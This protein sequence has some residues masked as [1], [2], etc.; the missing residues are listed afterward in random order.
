M[1]PLD[2]HLHDTLTQHAADVGAPV[3]LFGAV[4]RRARTLRRRRVAVATAGTAAVAAVAVVG[5]LTLTGG[6][7][8]DTLRAPI[9]HAGSGTPSATS[10]SPAASA[11]A[12]PSPV[13]T[14]T[15]Q[16]AASTNYPMS[17]PRVPD[18]AVAWVDWPAVQ[19]SMAGQLPAGFD[20]PQHLRPL[21]VFDT[22]AGAA[23]VFVAASGG[24]TVAGAVLQAA[25]TAAVAVHDID[26][27]AAQVS[28][29]VRVAASGG[30]VDDGLVVAAP[31]AGQILV[32]QP[33]QTTYSPVPGSN[34]RTAT[35][36]L[37]RVVPGQ[38]VAQIKVL[39]GNGDTDKPLY[40]GPIG[41]GYT[42]P[43]V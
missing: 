27:A 2:S 39:D 5:G 15:G 33:G 9:A 4:E 41:V 35:I 40:Q 7:D 8:N 30:A 37:G 24:R 22:D 23:T 1:S 10:P 12:T 32:Q 11:S 19:R 6:G 43:D 13:T 3:D 25:P 16:P 14:A 21:A 42:F 29:I 38:P 28:A 17:W 36:T 18:A 34:A 26:A 20:P 31:T